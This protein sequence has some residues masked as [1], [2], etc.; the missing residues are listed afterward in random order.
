MQRADSL[1]KTLML[2]KIEERMRRGRQ[3]TRWLDGFTNL[4]DMSLS[5]LWELVM[6]REAWNAAVHGVTKSRTGLCDWTELMCK[7]ISCAVGKG[8][9][10]WTVCSLNKTLLAFALLHFVLQ[11]QTCLLLQVSLDFLLLH[12]SPLWWKG[13]L[14]LV[15]VLE[16]LVGLHRLVTQLLQHYWLGHR[17]GLLW[18]WVVALEMTW[19]RSAIFEIEPKYCISESFVDYKGALYLSKGSCPQ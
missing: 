15:L 17:L 16:S 7:A 12:F 10:L 18:C 8:C 9:L 1:E 11:G 14:F 4:M 3:R 2:G 6:D 5:K 13:D 19:D